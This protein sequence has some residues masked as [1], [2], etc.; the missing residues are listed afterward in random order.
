MNPK[1][2]LSDDEVLNLSRLSETGAG[3]ALLK[4]LKFEIEKRQKDYDENPSVDD[5]EGKKDFRYKAGMIAGL[6]FIGQ[7]SQTAREMIVKS[8]ERKTS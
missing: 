2:A 6:K 1:S 8:E 4:L 5:K 7:A 3:Q